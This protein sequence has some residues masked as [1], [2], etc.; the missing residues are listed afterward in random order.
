MNEEKL[1]ADVK[2]NEAK[3]EALSNEIRYKQTL[4]LAKIG[5]WELDLAEGLFTF[6]D[7]FYEIF[8][9][10]V[11]KVGSYKLT[12]KEYAARFVHPDDQYVVEKEVQKAIETSDPQFSSYLEHKIIYED[13]SIG[14]MG[15]KYFIQKNENGETIKLYG[16]NQ[17][18]TERKQIERELYQVRENFKNNEAKYYALLTNLE[19]GVVVHAPDT[20]II[21]CNVRSQELLG[22]SE[23]QMRG[24]VALDPYWKF[25]YEDGNPIPIEDYPVM[26]VINTASPQRNQIV[27]VQRANNDMIWVLVNGFPIKNEQQDIIEIIIS[28]IDIT[29]RK[30][31]EE[32][33]RE[34]KEIAEQK[35]TQL[36]ETQKIAKIGSWHLDISTNKVTWTEEIYGMFGLDPEQ[37]APPYTEHMKLFTQASWNLL[38]EKLAITAEKGI[39][40]ELELETIRKDKNNGWMWVKGEAVLDQYNN[41]VGLQGVTLDITNRKQN[42]LKLK[43]TLEEK[44]RLFKELHH[45]IK[46]NLQMVSSLMYTKS[47]LTHDE[48]LNEFIQETINRVNSIA[49]IHDHLLQL[50]EFNNLFTKNYLE[51]LIKGVVSSLA[52]DSNKYPLQ[53]NIED[54]RMDV[55][56]ILAIGLITNE[57]ISNIIKHAYNPDMGGKIVVSFVKHAKDYT[58]TIRDEGKGM[59][60]NDQGKSKSVGLMMIDQLSK[61]LKGVLEY[62]TQDGTTCTVTFP[63]E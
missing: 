36:A 12:P 59:N 27:G 61:Q 46:N 16:V 28:F 15:V 45:R 54:H 22:L 3:Q 47:L 23:D 26:R 25:T 29:D 57:S 58:L 8:R 20:T 2:L 39:P 60:E 56:N 51:D 63:A 53:L 62:K 11:E 31:A 6:N 35:A 41:I 9:S 19:T 42:E 32:A 44:D 34:A 48:N 49:K 40:Y 13:G 55:D 24:K 43:K 50:E 10:S 14:Y 5:G 37:P 33:Q 4:S 18:I 21:T 1:K 38:S 7:S 17:E 30:L 52:Y